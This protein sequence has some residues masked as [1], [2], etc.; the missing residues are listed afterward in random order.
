M[1]APV[2]HAHHRRGARAQPQHRF[3]ARL[4]EAAAAAAARPEADRHLGNHRRRALLAG[5]SAG[6]AGDRGVRAPVSG[7]GALPAAAART[8][9][10]TTID[11]NEA[12]VDA[13]DERGALRA[14]RR[15]GVP[16][17]RARDPRGRRGAAQAPSAADRDPAAVRAPVG[18]GAGA[19]VQAARAAGA[20]CSRPTSPRP[21]S[22]CRASATSS[23]RARRASSATA[24]ATRSSSCRWRRSPRRART[25]APGRCGRVASGVCIRLY[26]EDDFSA[27]PAYTDPEVL[28]SSLAGVILRMKSLRLG[29]VED[30]PFLDPPA[31]K[32]ISRRLRAARRAGRGGRGERPDRD[33][34]AARAAAAR[35]AHRRMILAAKAEGSLAEVLVIA[36]AL[37]VQDPRERPLERAQARRRGAEEVRRREIGL[38]RLPEA[39]EVL[40][41]RRSRTRNRTASCAELC[42]EQFPL[43]Q[44]HARVARHPRQLKELR[45]RAGLEGVGEGRPSYA[46]IHRALLAGLLGNIG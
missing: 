3:P 40:S 28:R 43:L 44:P 6:R 4:P 45:R 39:V 36:A 8:R 25:S 17:R 46:Q 9:R 20:S 14:G 11:L 24:T 35:P 26:A 37:S 23:I 16:A 29:E 10:R 15:A 1:L 27:R 12:I 31:P 21:R 34:P 22:P 7:R 18:G 33:R 38:P 41:R 2:R 5:I 13:V 42:R 30:F 32:A 19:R